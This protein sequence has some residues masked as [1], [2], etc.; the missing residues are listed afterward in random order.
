MVVSKTKVNERMR[1]KTNSILVQ[2]IFL[3]KK[4]NLLDLASALSVPS[5]KLAAVNLGKINNSKSDVVIIPGK[6][7]SAGEIEKKVKIYALGFSQI[8]KEKLK[9]A[10]CETKTLLEG[11]K[12]DPKLKG[13]I[14][15]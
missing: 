12:K 8:A 3:A 14:I 15:I 11:L 9:K 13:E 2:T 5:R 10:G 1:N 6:V 7:L 4:N